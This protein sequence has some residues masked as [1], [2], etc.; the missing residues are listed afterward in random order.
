L[1]TYFLQIWLDWFVLPKRTKQA[2][3][4][5]RKGV[6]YIYIYSVVKLF[7]LRNIENI[8]KTYKQININ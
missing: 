6:H 4:D 2:S 5:Q 8:G 1:T 7:K 3:I